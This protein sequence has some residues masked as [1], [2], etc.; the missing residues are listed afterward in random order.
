MSLNNDSVAVDFSLIGALA[1]IL[2]L[3]AE[4]GRSESFSNDQSSYYAL[5]TLRLL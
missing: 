3:D 4:R 2:D 5:L 1:L